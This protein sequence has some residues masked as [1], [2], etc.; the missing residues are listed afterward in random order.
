MNQYYILVFI[1]AVIV[2][3]YDDIYDNDLYES[4]GISKKNIPYINEFLKSLFILGF[5]L[6]SIEYPFFFIFFTL[7]NLAGYF[8]TPDYGAF[9]LA[10]MISSIILIPFFKWNRDE[11]YFIN[12]VSILTGLIIA[13]MS[14]I[15]FNFKDVE[16]SYMKLI[17]RTFFLFIIILTLLI[18]MTFNFLT[19]SMIVILLF[20]M[21]YII[22]NSIFQYLLINKYIIPKNN[23]NNKIKNDEIK[24]D[25][26]EK[27]EIRND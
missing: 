5:S 13:Y 16:F 24:N 4:L 8:F 1:I 9:E 27:D 19:E 23:I 10:G 25:E 22:P 12:I 26:I 7:I 20:A 14:E 3:I 18:N 15:I 21:G 6:V 2:K 17:Y 11:K